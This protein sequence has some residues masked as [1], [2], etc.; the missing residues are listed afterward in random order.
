MIEEAVRLF[1]TLLEGVGDAEA[2]EAA[3]GSIAD[4]SDRIEGVAQGAPGAPDEFEALDLD[5]SLLRALTEYEEHRLRENLRR[6]HHILLV[7][8]TFEIIS[9]EEGLSELSEAARASGEVLSTLPAPGEASESQIR[10]SLLVAS[11]L[12]ADEFGSSL[13]LPNASVRSV[14]PGGK[15]TPEAPA[16]PPAA[17][18]APPATADVD[19][20]HSEGAR[21]TATSA[22]SEGVESLKS[23]SETVRVD[24]RKLDE[25]MNLVGELVIQRAGRSR[26]CSRR[27]SRCAWFHCGRSS[28]RYLAWSGVFAW[29]SRRTSVSSSAARTRNSTS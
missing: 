24:I 22:E 25:L 18:D 5:S 3:A 20:D 23:I 1:A 14:T 28:K 19:R 8:S 26:S 17:L 7:D 9:F 13:D 6:G 10:F 29:S 15:A 11:E 21:P 16:P 12:D 27:C 4:L 2:L